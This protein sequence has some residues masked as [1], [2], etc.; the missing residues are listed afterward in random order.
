M[1]RFF[2]FILISTFVVS[3]LPALAF[4]P[5]DYR[6]N[7][8][9]PP[10]HYCDPTRSL[11]NNGTGT[12]GDPWNMSQCA[13]QPVAGDVVG[14]L[15]GVSVRIPTTN[16]D[17]FPAFNPS[18]SGTST[19]RIVY[20]TKY[21]AVA[22]AGVETNAN[23]TELRHNGSMPTIV[24]GVGSGTGC[25]MYG[26]NGR[27]Y[28]TFDGFYTDMA[29]AYMKEDSGVIRA[30]NATGIHFRNFV[31]KGANLTVASNAIL[32]RPQ[33]TVDIVLSNFKAY[34][35]HNNGTGSNTPQPAAFSDQYGDRN[36]LIEHF[37]ISN[38][39]N[40]PFLK[41]TAPSN[42]NYNYGTIRYGIIRNMTAGCLRFNDFDAANLTTVHHILCYD[43]GAY[44]MALSS[45]TTDPRNVLFHHNTFA[46][47]NST[48]INQHGPVYIKNAASMSNVTIRD[49]IF[50]LDNGTYGN[51]VDGGENPAPR[52]T[53]NYNVYTK[54]GGATNWSHNGAN[55]TTIAAWRTAVSPTQEANSFV[56][57]TPLFT[58]RNGAD[59]TIASGHAALTASSTGGQLGAYE[60]GVIVGVDTTGASSA[61]APVDLTPPAAPIGTRIQ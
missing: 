2:K 29:Q 27:N 4:D 57:T 49:S 41:G 3:A 58:N 5:S 7:T 21:A 52:P 12:V 14:V 30:E 15:P 10:N 34:D 50:D 38:G 23:R 46:R 53:M 19:N 40:G 59:F 45:E 39:D 16:N 44:G 61:P 24:N 43:Y 22:L 48:N 6:Q 25:A 26:S 51:M 42:V 28:I 47:G 33:N 8:Y 56:S 35:F 55:Y 18:N 20:V 60:G 1:K 54:N 9:G 17:N 36:F 13:T 31:I 37:E 11:T 32:Y